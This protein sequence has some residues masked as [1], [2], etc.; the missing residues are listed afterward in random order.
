MHSNAYVGSNTIFDA[1]LVHTDT[2]GS[3]SVPV[4]QR[5]DIVEERREDVSIDGGSC[6][7]DRTGDI[8][9]TLY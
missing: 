8:D 9:Q 1:N 4:R 5:R 3:G 6:D 7:G 2:V